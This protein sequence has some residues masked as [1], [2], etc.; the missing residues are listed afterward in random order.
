MKNWL[1]KRIAKGLPM[2]ND[3]REQLVSLVKKLEKDMLEKSKIEKSKKG[4]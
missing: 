1:K 3:N 4:A 2:D